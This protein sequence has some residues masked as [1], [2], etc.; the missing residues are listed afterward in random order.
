MVLRPASNSSFTATSVVL[1]GVWNLCSCIYR[2]FLCL[3]RFHRVQRRQTVFC[4]DKS[5]TGTIG[6]F[7]VS[8]IL[9]HASEK[10]ADL[11]TWHGSVMPAWDLN[12]TNPQR[13]SWDLRQLTSFWPRNTLNPPECPHNQNWSRKPYN[14]DFWKATMILLA[15]F[16]LLDTLSDPKGLIR[17]GKK[18]LVSNHHQAW[19]SNNGESHGKE[20]GK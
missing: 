13:P 1:Q 10:P 19:S 15:A 17:N 5:T 6:T 20:N 12:E 8:A 9:R 14:T 16:G 7:G 3:S 18:D 2:L 11:L 4:K